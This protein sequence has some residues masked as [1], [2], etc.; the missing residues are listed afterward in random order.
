MGVVEYSFDY[1]KIVYSFDNKGFEFYF[2]YIVD[3]VSG[4]LFLDYLEN[5]LGSLEWCVGL[6]YLFYVK[7]DDYY[8]FKWV[9]C[10]KVGMF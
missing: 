3:L 10:Y 6:D 7:L 8:W 2:V 1:I 5:L 9:Y 4:D